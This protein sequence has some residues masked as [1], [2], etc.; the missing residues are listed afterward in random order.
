MTDT[1]TPWPTERPDAETMR[2]IAADELVYAVAYQFATCGRGNWVASERLGL[3]ERIIA[4]HD[5]YA[6][7]TALI[8]ADPAEADRVA[9]LMWL[10]ADAGDAY[11]ELAIAAGEAVGLDVEAISKTAKRDADAEVAE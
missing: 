5:R 10:A 9:G 8:A 4:A 7:L 3:S 6:L 11:G 2:R 1:P